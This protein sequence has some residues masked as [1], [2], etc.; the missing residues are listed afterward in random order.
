M[1]ACQS[2]SAAVH[3]IGGLIEAAVLPDTHS[4][5]IF[6][7]ARLPRA[8]QVR[9]RGFWQ[10]IDAYY[11]VEEYCGKG[12][13]LHTSVTT[14]DKYSEQFVALR[15]VVPLLEVLDFLHQQ[16]IAHR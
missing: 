5:L 15:I 4:V 7:C 14:P 6:T 1:I 8:L 12:D 10:E 3:C 2:V 16:G 11:M 9:C 13:A